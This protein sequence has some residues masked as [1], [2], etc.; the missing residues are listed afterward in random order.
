MGTPRDFRRP[1]ESL[2]KILSVNMSLDP[3]GGGGTA[4]RTFQVSRALVRAGAECTVLTTDIGIDHTRQQA[5]SGVEV[6]ALPCLMKRFYIPAVTS[7]R[8][9][10][11]AASC[12]VIE[13]VN[14]WTFLNVLVYRAAKRL[15]KPYIVCPAGALPIFGRSRLLKSLYNRAVGKEIIRKADGCVAISITEIPQFQEYG[16]T[17][18]KI[19]LIP[20]G[21][22]SEDYRRNIAANDRRQFG[23][24]NS[25]FILFMG[26]LNSIKGPDLLLEA[27]LRCQ[28]R[29][30]D[31]HLVFAGPDDGMLSKLKATAEA[32]DASNRIHFPGYLGRESKLSIYQAADLLVIPS[33]EEAMS[34]VVLEAGMVGTPVLLTDQCGFSEVSTVGGG[35]V[36]SATVDGICSGLIKMLSDPAELEKMGANLGKYIESHYTWD[37]MIRKYLDLYNRILSEPYK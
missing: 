3:V 15:K 18:D 28:D 11:I 2:V 20:N 31:F 4:E 13:L 33:R 35:R 1:F 6:V 29:F 30:P 16:L 9:L 26:R 24:Q 17:A 23:P 7:R 19:T 25:P 14:H 32:S 22:D 8:I 27:F 10:S 21:V 36:V 12:D 5:L 34:L 37:I